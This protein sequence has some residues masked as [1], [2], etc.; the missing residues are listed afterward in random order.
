MERFDG[1]VLGGGPA[2][3]V[4]AMLLAQQGLQVAV[5]RPLIAEPPQF[6][7]TTALLTSS[8]ALIRHFGIWPALA[9]AVAPL[10]KMRLIDDRGHL[11]RTPTLTF[12]A[13]ELG[14]DAFG[15][16]I[17]NAALNRAL[18]HA[19]RDM[20]GIILIDG[21]AATIDGDD[22]EAR[23]HCTDHRE[24][25]A[26]L[27]VGADGRHS[28]A[29]KAS[30][31]TTRSWSYPQTALTANLAHKVDHRGTS[32]E[33]HTSS[34]PFTLVPLPGRASSLVAVVSPQDGQRLMSL[35]NEAL[36][37]ELTRCS[38]HLLG[39]LSITSKPGTFPLGG[40]VMANFARGRIAL[41]GDAA[42]GLPPI[43]AQGLNLGLR[44]A[45][46][47]ADAVMAARKRSDD[48]AHPAVMAA[49]N[50]A[51]RAD[52]WSR[53][54]AIDLVNRSLLSSFLPFDVARGL[55][56]STARDIPALRRLLMRGALPPRAFDEAMGRLGITLNGNS[57]AGPLPL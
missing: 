31:M 51:R 48:P 29:R 23:I 3:L 25:S 9:Q 2:G 46:H 11:W 49:Y 33:F 44:D 12:D 54:A 38:H 45:V 1:L 19:A 30:G 42:H 34:G 39:S 36:A 43:G 14:L 15:Y 8:I 21:E 47:L 5:L 32:S 27:I 7:R 37:H 57:P 56:M 24:F 41:V 22:R 35:D 18:E 6:A 40:H 16:N 20:A 4:S 50:Q 53:T 26:R 13:G 52:I 55:I 28:L 10:K 17:P